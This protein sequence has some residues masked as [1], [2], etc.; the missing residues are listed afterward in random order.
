MKDEGGP[1]PLP[2]PARDGDGGRSPSGPPLPFSL[3]VMAARAARRWAGTRG[4]GTEGGE[5]AVGGQSAVVPVCPARGA[6]WS[7]S[8][9]VAS[10]CLLASA[11]GRGSAG[12]MAAEAADSWGRWWP[13]RPAGVP[14]DPARSVPRSPALLSPTD[15]DSF[16]VVE[17]V[18][19]R[20]VPGVA[21]DRWA[22]ED[23]EDDVKV[24]PAG[25]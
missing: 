22:G 11:G 24:R 7:R 14:P 18:A 9:A 19:K 15:A 16:E 17:P 4:D 6:G 23:E 12:K 8:G 20:L 21:G 25:P 13:P 2:Q 10:P 1:A 5:R 3:P